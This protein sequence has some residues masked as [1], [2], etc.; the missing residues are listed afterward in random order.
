M[1]HTDSWYTPVFCATCFTQIVGTLICFVR[2]VSHRLLVH[3]YVLCDMF[4]TDSWYTHMF[5]ATCF[6]QIVGTLICFVRHVSHRLLVHS[7]VL[8]DMFHT[9][10]WYTHMFCTTWFTYIVNFKV[11]GKLNQIELSL[12]LLFK[13]R[14]IFSE[15]RKN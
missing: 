8:C 10:C 14:I 1:F 4:H 2:H 11:L 13:S 12:S 6:T 7:Y 3:S 5:C 9:D 15:C